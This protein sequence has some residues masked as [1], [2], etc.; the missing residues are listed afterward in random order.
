VAITID[1]RW[2][3]DSDPDGFGAA[4]D[5]LVERGDLVLLERNRFQHRITTTG[6]PICYELIVGTTGG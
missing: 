1:E 6:E 4:V 3:G 2:M 5:R